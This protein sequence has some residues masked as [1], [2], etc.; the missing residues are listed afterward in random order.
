MCC[1][2]VRVHGDKTR[3]FIKMSE[4]VFLVNF[5][6]LEVLRNSLHCMYVI[7]AGVLMWG[8]KGPK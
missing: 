7:A 5:D 6:Y 3:A 8:V 2:G 1:E 4:I